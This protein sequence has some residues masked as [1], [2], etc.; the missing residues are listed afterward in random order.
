M[1]RRSTV[2]VRNMARQ[3]YVSNVLSERSATREKV[4]GARE[5]RVAWYL[6]E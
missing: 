3:M 5:C 4:S 1:V 2:P 6:H